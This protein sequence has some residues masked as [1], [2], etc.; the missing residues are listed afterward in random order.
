MELWLYNLTLEECAQKCDASSLCKGFDRNYE[1]G[2]CRFASEIGG[3]NDTDGKFK[4]FTKP[5]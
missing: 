2:Y 1:L 4:Y 3:I 5:Q